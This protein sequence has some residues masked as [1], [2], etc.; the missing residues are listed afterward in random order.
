[1]A[2]A[3]HSSSQKLLF[4]CHPFKS[5]RTPYKNKNAFKVAVA[6]K[7][8]NLENMETKYNIYYSNL[9]TEID[10]AD[11]K[12]LPIDITAKKLPHDNKS[13]YPRPRDP[14][15][16]YTP[17]KGQFDLIFSISCDYDIWK[18]DRY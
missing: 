15:K 14:T 16:L 18:E 7:N 2:A 8:Y 10:P 12:T 11:K 3:N 13:K 5:F 4:I 1:M 6:Q 9:P 17:L